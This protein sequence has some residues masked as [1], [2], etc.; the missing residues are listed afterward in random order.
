MRAYK[1]RPFLSNLSL[2]GSTKVDMAKKG[3]CRQ[4]QAIHG[5][6]RPI[7]LKKET[8]LTHKMGVKE[9]TGILLAIKLN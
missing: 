5:E 6:A 3:N 4:L 1:Q 7:S 9:L 2:N 8:L